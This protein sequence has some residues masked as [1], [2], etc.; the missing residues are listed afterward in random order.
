MSRKQ[1]QEGSLNATRLVAI[2][3]PCK[4]QLN[5]PERAYLLYFT[6]FL[7]W[8]SPLYDQ[9]VSQIDFGR[10]ERRILY[11]GSVFISAFFLIFQRTLNLTIKC[12]LTGN[13]AIMTAPQN[14]EM[15]TK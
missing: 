12:N 13:A 7:S 3:A 1:E 6:D 5:P 11:V 15:K 9:K 14:R 2:P 10:L 8:P 4:Q